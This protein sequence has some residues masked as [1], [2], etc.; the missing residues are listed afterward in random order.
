MKKFVTKAEVAEYMS[1]LA[2]RYMADG[3]VICVDGTKRF[4]DDGAKLDIEL[5]GRGK[6]T[7]A[8]RIAFRSDDIDPF[9]FVT[10]FSLE[11]R[12][13]DLGARGDNWFGGWAGAEVVESIDL[14]RI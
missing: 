13:F 1:D 12:E 2:G 8:V 6:S 5:R 10:R 4:Y 3:Y 11:A 7:K 14:Y 9:S